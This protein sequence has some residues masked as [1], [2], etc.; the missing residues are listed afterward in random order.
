MGHGNSSVEKESVAVRDLAWGDVC[1]R[2][3]AGDLGQFLGQ[4][5]EKVGVD[6]A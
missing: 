2:Q 6:E 3:D 4:W 1:V 5:C